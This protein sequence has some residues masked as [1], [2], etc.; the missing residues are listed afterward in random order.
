[1]PP[2]DRRGRRACYAR[3]QNALT[4]T[5]I[6]AK[7]NEVAAA[8][9][10]S[11]GTVSKFIN[12]T[13]RF[14]P[15]VERRIAE[16]IAQL[17][18]ESNPLARSMA[19]GQT[20]AVGVVIQD[21]LNPYFTAMVK[22]VNRIAQRNDF[23]VLIVDADENRKG[24]RPALT[25]LSRRVDGLILNTSMPDDDLRWTASLGKPVVAVGSAPRDGLLTLYSDPNR[26]GE[27]LAQHLLMEKYQR[28]AYISLPNARGDDERRAGTEQ[29]LARAG[30]PLR[31]FSVPRATVADGERVCASVMLSAE[32][33]DA[34][35][36]YNDMIAAGFIKEAE[37]LGI[38][39]PHDVAVCGFDNLELGKLTSPTLTSIDTETERAGEVAMTTLLD[40]LAGKSPDPHT[41]LE[42]RLVVR[43]S[44][45][46]PRDTRR[47]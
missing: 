33:P 22:G 17:G 36:C 15:D 45:V 29:V 3:R 23:V 8:A 42:A 35:I 14:S 41:M 4:L 20:G 10:V 28:F 11:I 24:E 31:T 37:R 38:A 18:Y 46:R 40:A 47:R 26:A 43:E 30:L 1:M 6:V 19:T 7:I 12:K 2:R 27:M 21:I 13:K 9:G 32:P 5:F 25:K 16:A 39:I 44:T 34:V